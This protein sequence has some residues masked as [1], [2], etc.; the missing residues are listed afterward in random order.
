M[1]DLY[2]EELMD[3][4]KNPARRGKMSDS[5]V[6]AAQKNP[7]CGDDINLQLKIE[8]GIIKDAKF[9]G[10]ACL[11][12]I[13]SSEMLLDYLIGKTVEEAK[14][15]SKDQLLNMLNLNLTTSRIGCATLTL[16]ALHKALVDYE[17]KR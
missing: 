12:S 16:T 4:Y 15:V 6:S 17:K 2:R 8:K 7:M 9:E 14:N 11:V 1:S 10:S 5:D 13:V 3:I